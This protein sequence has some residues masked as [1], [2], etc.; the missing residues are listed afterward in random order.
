MFHLTTSLNCFLERCFFIVSVVWGLSAVYLACQLTI[1]HF[2]FERG[3][4]SSQSLYLTKE[5]LSN[6]INR[7]QDPHIAKEQQQPSFSPYPRKNLSTAFIYFMVHIAYQT[8]FKSTESPI[9]HSRDTKRDSLSNI[10]PPPVHEMR[11]EPTYW[12][13]QALDRVRS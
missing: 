11:T 4:L 6:C 9:S 5:N 13:L 10:F 8:F 2:T 12:P 7:N 1:R 3:H